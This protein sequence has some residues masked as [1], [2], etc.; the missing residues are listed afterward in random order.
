MVPR[1]VLAVCVCLPGLAALVGCQCDSA[2]TARPQPELS[3]VLHVSIR[4]SLLYSGTAVLQIR[5]T[6]P[7]SLKNLVIV[8][9]NED[10]NHRSSYSLESLEP[11]QTQ[12]VGV[13]EANW[14]VEPNETIELRCPGYQS[15][16]YV[17]Y[18]TSEG[19]VGIREPWW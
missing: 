5:N 15:F 18:R 12:E 9:H 14:K 6:S 10:S 11:G 8:F 7:A 1:S 16:K 4:P 17:T 3:S 19:A 13:L 2:P